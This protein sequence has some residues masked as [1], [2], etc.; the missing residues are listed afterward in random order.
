MKR[1]LVI[2][3]SPIF[4]DFLQS[5][6]KS[7]QVVTEF[8]VGNRDA[9]TKI[10]TYLPD[11][12]IVEVGNE[13]TEE[14][15]NLLEKKHNDVNAKQIPIVMAGGNI[16]NLTIVS[17]SEYGVVKYFKKPIRF[18]LFFNFI[19]SILRTNFSMDETPC[20]LDIHLNNDIIFI[21]ISRGINREKLHILKYKISEIISKNKFEDPKI[22]LMLTNLELT[23]IDSINLEL[24]L[25]NITSDE[26][27]NPN[28]IKIL[29]FSEFLRKLIEGHPK[30]SHIE[31]V[32]SLNDVLSDFVEERTTGN[33]QNLIA[34]KI[35]ESDK[36][37]SNDEIELRYQD[38]A[39]PKE[40]N[41]QIK[42]AVVDDDP[43]ILN[44]LQ[45]AFEAANMPIIKY[46]SGSQF[47]KDVIAG[48]KF[49]LVILDI[50]IPDMDGFSILTS[51]TNHNFT[52][53][54]I[55]YSQ[56]TQKDYIYKA[57]SL[58]AKTYLSKIQKPNAVVNKAVEILRST[59]RG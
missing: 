30:Y 47:I 3:G 37:V 28:R 29:S 31:I 22:I 2:D 19:G 24:L 45:A 9:Y 36:P 46:A 1:V 42:I 17:L 35:L 32:N 52:N 33:E 56:A 43:L 23:F 38:K 7:E 25:D 18:D 21:E 12:I 54:V 4:C 11:L 16:E 5:K 51:L 34:E 39:A 55:V 59:P 27:V 41:D 58:G 48:Q 13:I 8:A 57:I 50:F 6:L 10:I 20:I 49:D 40:L 14:T 53:P 15:R 26:R 44:V